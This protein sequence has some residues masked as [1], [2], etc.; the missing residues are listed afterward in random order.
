[1]IRYL[2][3]LF[4]L[5]AGFDPRII[6]LLLLRESDKNKKRNQICI[7]FGNH[8]QEFF[9]KKIYG[10]KVKLFYLKDAFE[11]NANGKI[12]YLVSSA[13]PTGW[14]WA[15]LYFKVTG[16]RVVLNQN[17]V[18][19]PD[20]M[21][22]LYPLANLSNRI[23]YKYADYV[24]YQ[25]KFCR[26]MAAKYLNNKKV[27]SRILY[28]PAVNYK[29]PLKSNRK[30]LNISLMGNQ[31]E[32]Y[33]LNRAIK[34]ASILRRK[35][36]KFTLKIYGSLNWTSNA[37]KN[38]RYLM[39]SINQEEL[40]ENVIYEGPYNRD[41]LS[42]ILR[43]T[44][45]LLHTKSLDP[46]P[47]SVVEAIRN[48]IPVVYIKNGGT[49]ELVGPGGIGVDLKEGKNWPCDTLENKLAEAISAVILDN[50]EFSKSARRHGVKY[51]V[52]KWVE[53]HDRIFRKI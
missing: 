25:S 11:E 49:S 44:D 30:S 17:G 22:F 9:E 28:N 45:I 6:P 3:Y 18:Y 52:K 43:K 19:Y 48:G 15:L 12:L 37:V 26:K 24:I 20:M 39:K 51:S 36:I 35:K 7:F 31:Y 40:Q 29:L 14:I 42:S 46:C 34:I 8:N 53:E 2:K 32:K 41:A 10:G 5:A 27:N 16:R 47:S 4:N 1:M 33:R 23:I 50:S 38:K 21:P 13:L